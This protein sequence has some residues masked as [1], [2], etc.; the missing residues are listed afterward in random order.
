MQKTA[1]AI[2]HSGSFLN[3]GFWILAPD[4]CRLHVAMAE[5]GLL[6]LPEK[7]CAFW[8]TA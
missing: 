1:G 5:L 8:L 2:A 3:S 7:V 4:C 6:R